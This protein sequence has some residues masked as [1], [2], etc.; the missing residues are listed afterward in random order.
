MKTLYFVLALLILTGFS[1]FIGCK[2]DTTTQPTDNT[3]TPTQSAGPEAYFPIK[4]GLSWKYKVTFPA[5]VSLPY[6]PVIEYPEGML[7]SSITHGMLSWNQGTD[8]VIMSTT[9]VVESTA[10]FLTYETTLNQTGYKFFFSMT[11]NYHVYLRKKIAGSVYTYDL[12]GEIP[13]AIPGWRIARRMCMISPDSLNTKMD[14]TVPAGVF[15]DCIRV[16]T[17][18]YGDGNYVPSGTYPIEMYYSQ[19]KGMVKAIGWNSNGTMAYTME[20]LQ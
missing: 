2:E 12:V 6:R 20:L 13:V 5:T 11:G 16:F 18:I 15:N 4:A 8:T 7:A 1:Q 10:T 14:I 19:D 3:N 17:A 9:T